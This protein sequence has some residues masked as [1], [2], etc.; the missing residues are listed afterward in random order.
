MKSKNLV[1]LI[2]LAIF[3][4][5]LFAGCSPAA[6]VDV[7][8][9]PAVDGTK[10]GSDPGLVTD[11]SQEYPDA[12]N[13]VLDALKNQV[14]ELRLGDLRFEEVEWRD[15]CLEL[16][17]PDEM[18]I[19]ALVP[20]YLVVVEIDGQ[21]YTFHTDQTGEYIRQDM[22]NEG[23]RTPGTGELDMDNYPEAVK[24][25]LQALEEQ[26]GSLRQVSVSYEHVEWRDGCLELAEPDEMCTM[27]LVPGWRVVIEN[28][29]QT[30][31]YHTDETGRYFRQ[32]SDA[33][34]S[35]P[36]GDTE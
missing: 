12:V 36:R 3:S 33:N 10:T 26:V 34:Q 32:A 24:V 25:V 21:T 6:P 4:L 22:A 1:Y 13:A 31:L 9:P 8:T 5:S 15:G 29:G 30:Y 11:P 35:P 2:A 19:M 16:A 27:A 23:A 14:G 28:D 7:P 20:G 18:C 17:E